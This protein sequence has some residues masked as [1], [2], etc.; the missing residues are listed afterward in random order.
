MAATTQWMTE[1]G[2]C[3]T[4][5]HVP[6]CGYASVIV[7]GEVVW[8]CHADDHSCYAPSGAVPDLL[9]DLERSLQRARVRQA[10]SGR[11]PDTDNQNPEA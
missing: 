5:G 8:L 4:C 11:N 6:A 9:G 2:P 10:S 3:G 1:P 7:D